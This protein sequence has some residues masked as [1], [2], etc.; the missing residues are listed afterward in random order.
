MKGETIQLSPSSPRL[1]VQQIYRIVFALYQ[2]RRRQT[3]HCHHTGGSLFRRRQVLAHA[4]TLSTRGLC[5][6]A[7]RE[8]RVRLHKNNNFDVTSLR[9]LS[10][11]PAALYSRSPVLPAAV[12]LPGSGTKDLRRA[13]ECEEHQCSTSAKSDSYGHGRQVRSGPRG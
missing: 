1:C 11:I 13:E 2:K 8:R 7:I 12:R 9:V 5:L 6:P 4:V 3:Q 10:T